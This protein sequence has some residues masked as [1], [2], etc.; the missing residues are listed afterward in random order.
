MEGKRHDWLL[1]AL[2]VSNLLLDLSSLGVRLLAKAYGLNTQLLGPEKTK[3]RLIRTSLKEQNPLSPQDRFDY[4][5]DQ[6][7]LYR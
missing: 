5:S 4:I 1:P 2:I 7:A 6:S 3:Q